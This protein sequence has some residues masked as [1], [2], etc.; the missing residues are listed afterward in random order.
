MRAGTTPPLRHLDGRCGHRPLRA[1]PSRDHAA[2]LSRSTLAAALRRHVHARRRSIAR[3]DA[4]LTLLIEAAQ[5]EA[6]EE[7]LPQI[8]VD[9]LREQADWGHYQLEPTPKATNRKG[10]IDRVETPVAASSQPWTFR[11]LSGRL[12]PFIATMASELKMRT[13]LKDLAGARPNAP[14]PQDTGLGNYFRATYGVGKETISQDIPAT[15]LLEMLATALLITRNCILGMFGEQAERI[16]RHPLYF[17]CVTVPLKSFYWLA[18]ALRR[19]PASARTIMLGVLL[20]CLLARTAAAFFWG[21][22]IHPSSGWNLRAV[23]WFIV[24]PAMVLLG[25]LAVVRVVARKR[26]E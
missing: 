15:V 5:L 2:T 10:T 25:Q 20:G 21:D 16:K 14:S 4:E 8:G 12:D 18:V 23:L 1:A 19:S 17:I 7:D 11:P 26:V 3:H 13:F 22:L 9:A 6:V 24:V